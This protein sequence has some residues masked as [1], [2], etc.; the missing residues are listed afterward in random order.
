MN[1]TCPSALMDV[2]VAHHGSAHVD[3]IG[4]GRANLWRRSGTRDMLN[5]CPSDRTSNN[6]FSHHDTMRR[7][8][9]SDTMTLSRV[10]L[11]GRR[12]LESS[13]T[14]A[15]ANYAAEVFV[16]LIEV[17]GTSNPVLGSEDEVCFLGNFYL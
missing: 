8:D 5:L 3:P 2:P 6:V 17:H 14:A 11:S 4:E 13:R 15:F 9:A 10:F 16:T 1:P 7:T 12:E